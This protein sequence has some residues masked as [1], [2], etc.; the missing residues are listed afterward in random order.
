MQVLLFL[1]LLIFYFPIID[2]LFGSWR[3]NPFYSHGVIIPLISLFFIWRKKHLLESKDAAFGKGLGVLAAG[4]FAYAV[5]IFYKSVFFGAS[6]FIVVLTGLVIMSRGTKGLKVLGFPL[7]FLFFAVPIPVLG[8]VAVV[9]QVFTAKAS[10][11]V[12]EAFGVPVILKGAQISLADTA[13]VIGLPC[14]GMRSMISL[15]ALAA[16][17]SYILDCPAKKKFLVFLAA[18]PLA[19]IFNIGRV[20][21]LLWVAYGYGRES[22]M[23]LHDLLGIAYFLLSLTFLIILARLLGC[24]KLRNI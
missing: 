22:A 15:L 14:S 17:Y 11:W 13:Y 16:L 23:G 7:L 24:R 4:L 10:A 6:S 21:F 18:E 20:S 8:D 2:A 3:V 1:L 19:V 12:L 5:A 9:L